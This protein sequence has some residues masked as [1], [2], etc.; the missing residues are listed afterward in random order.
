MELT[1]KGHQ[2][3]TQTFFSAPGYRVHPGAFFVGI[4]AENR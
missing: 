2:K 3:H 4:H 1:A